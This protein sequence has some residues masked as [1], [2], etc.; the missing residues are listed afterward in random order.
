MFEAGGRA[1]P[2]TVRRSPTAKRM[3]LAI[4]PR[5]GA[6]ILSLPRRAALAR[7][8]AWVDEQR[9]WV[10]A[11]LAKLPPRQIL[12]PGGALP[13]E[14]ADRAIE[15]RADLPRAPRL[16]A[17]RIQLGGPRDA[18]ASRL[19]AWAK[20]EARRVLEA[21]TRTLAAEHGIA[22][23]RVGVGDPRSRWGS[24]AARGDIR[25]SWRLM[26]AP[27]FVRHA[28]I[29]HEIAHRVHMDHS[30]AFHA[31]AAKLTGFDPARS[32]AWLRAHGAALHALSV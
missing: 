12:E 8:L 29:A 22:V 9:L 4:D 24:C 11:A 32:K 3:R 18:V 14:G 28:T 5:E 13:W 15:W 31:L 23:G 26:M 10:E 16:F 19:L 27:A 21:E 1:H 20:R 2:L 17:D 30:P 7:G 6:V 25:Y